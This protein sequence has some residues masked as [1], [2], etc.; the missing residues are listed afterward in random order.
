MKTVVNFI[1][2]KSGSM[3]ANQEA[4]ISGFNEYIATLKSKKKKTDDILFSL[5]L[6]DTNVLQKYV[7]IP[8][9]EVKK[10]TKESYV[11]DGFTALYDAVVETVEKVN[12]K[13]DEI[14]GETKHL[15]V[16]MTDGQENSSTLHNENCLK[17][18]IKKLG[19][20]NWTFV[21]L[22]ANQDSWATTLNWGLATSNV[23][24]WTNSTP[25]QVNTC[26]ASLANSTMDFAC[27][28]TGSTNNFF[29]KK[30]LSNDS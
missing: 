20:K 14:K 2:D 30:D 19:E 4:T 18:L 12:E 13:V 25:A 5:T 3:F 16:I 21:F 1:L 10:L 26:F 28:N 15:V 17:D 29:T 27:S 8:I 6:F 22:G 9:K 24:N 23:A 11:P 7:A